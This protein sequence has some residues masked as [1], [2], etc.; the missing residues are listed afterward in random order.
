MEFLVPLLQDMCHDDPKKRPTIDDAVARFAKLT[1]SLPG[2]KLRSRLQQVGDKDS[3]S[4]F[5]GHWAKQIVRIV[6]RVPSIPRPPPRG[7]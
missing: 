5:A 4:L 1:K 6:S 3:L 7:I 2:W